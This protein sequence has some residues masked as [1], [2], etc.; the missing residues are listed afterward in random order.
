MVGRSEGVENI[1][2]TAE[3]A[4][5][6]A[7]TLAASGDAAYMVTA[8]RESEAS[9]AIAVMTMAERYG[10][11]LVAAHTAALGTAV[12]RAMAVRGSRLAAWR[13]LVCN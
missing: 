10:G 11:R 13:D 5:A 9:G 1:W 2:S 12:T 4:A 3:I 6:A 8:A 7:R